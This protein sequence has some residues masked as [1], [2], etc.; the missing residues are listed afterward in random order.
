VNARQTESS[1]SPC[2]LVVKTPVASRQPVADRMASTGQRLAGEVED[3]AREQEAT[4]AAVQEALG[5]LGV[6]PVT[7]SVD[8]LDEAAR[9]TIASARLVVTVGGDG[10]LL[11]AAH[12][13]TGGALL[14]VNSAPRSSVGYLTSTRRASVARV[15]E[16]IARGALLPQP[17]AR[18]EIELEGK[19]LP[20]ALNDVL[21]AH[22]QPAAT[23]RYRLRLGRRAEDHRSSGLWVAS[24]AGSTAGI[25]S[26]GGEA[27]PLGDRR[28]QLR[29]RELYRARGGSAVLASGFV[30]PGQE[31]IVESAMA[32]GRLF[33]DG[34]RMAVR[35]PFGAHAI[36]RVAEQPLRLF[37]DSAR[38]AAE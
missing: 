36:F 22:E 20:P 14:G 34:A 9:R 32:S 24:A 8:A 26:A 19:L 16:R 23:S 10:T 15:L 7:V 31:L 18:L 29:A 38:W 13:V 30:E 27:M 35:F 6:A 4:L 3:A 17:V 11:A 33:P 1:I 21:L 12:W 2:V 5:H 37:A 28:L 25:H